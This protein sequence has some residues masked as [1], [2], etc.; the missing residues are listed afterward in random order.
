MRV[1]QLA[2]A[3]I[4][5]AIT[6]T[7]CEKRNVAEGTETATITMSGTQEV[8]PN[9]S[10]A[11]GTIN[12]VYDR[13]TKTLTYSASWS[14]LTDTLTGMHI[15]GPADPGSNAGIL[16]NIIASGS[17]SGGVTL[18]NP[19]PSFIRQGSI[20]GR[21]LMDNVKL[22]ENDLLAGK[23]YINVHSKA[24]PGGEIRGNLIFQ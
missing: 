22:F 15:H 18:F 1:K 7:A 6:F 23:Y 4:I 10:T 2:A 24:Y 12:A 8:P 14:G 5:T 20:S 11:T 13:A 19:G 3:I 17:V 21:V 9:N 16:Q